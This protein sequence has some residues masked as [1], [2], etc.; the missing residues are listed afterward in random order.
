ML[1]I[2]IYVASLYRSNKK[3]VRRKT[4][5]VIEQRERKKKMIEVG[6][7]QVKM[8]LR[9]CNAPFIYYNDAIIDMSTFRAFYTHQYT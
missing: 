1:D 7:N 3:L 9:C 5:D 8:L 2:L 4:R 6:K